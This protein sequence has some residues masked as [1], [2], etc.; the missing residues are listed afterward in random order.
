M[1]FYTLMYFVH[2]KSISKVKIIKYKDINIDIKFGYLQD[3]YLVDLYK[4]R[5]FFT[6]VLLSK[7]IFCNF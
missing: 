5:F 4:K 3:L 7:D 2:F 1:N 6:H